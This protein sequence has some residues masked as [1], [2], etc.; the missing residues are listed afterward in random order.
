MGYILMIMIGFKMWL[1]EI[2][3]SLDHEI[4]SE[5]I[6]I[7]ENLIHLERTIKI[8]NDIVCMMNIDESILFTSN[9]EA[10]NI[11]KL[12]IIFNVNFAD[13]NLCFLHYCFEDRVHH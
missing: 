10:R 7:L 4:G 6:M 12:C 8:S 2:Y 5:L 1:Y 13:V 11:D 9:E 3:N